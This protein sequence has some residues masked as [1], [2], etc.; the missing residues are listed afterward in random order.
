MRD[1]PRRDRRPPRNC[2]GD[3]IT[4]FWR[5]GQ[6]S[7]S[8]PSWK[9]SDCMPRTALQARKVTEQLI[10]QWVARQPIPEENA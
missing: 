10:N 2:G 5:V 7:S 6:Y 1:G 4:R 3:P 8:R 9:P